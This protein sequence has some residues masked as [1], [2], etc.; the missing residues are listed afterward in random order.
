MTNVQIC[1]PIAPLTPT[2]VRP[3]HCL[4]EIHA[5]GALFWFYESQVTANILSSPHTA[6]FD[7]N[8]SLQ[9]LNEIPLLLVGS[10]LIES[11]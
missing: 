1:H 5:F 4:L 7:V 9:K 6:G 10:V 8:P 3:L 2:R 11:S